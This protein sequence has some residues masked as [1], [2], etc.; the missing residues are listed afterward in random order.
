MRHT[1][2]AEQWVPYPLPMLFAFFANPGNLPRLMPDWQKAR[3]EEASIIAP[4]PRPEF[5]SGTIAAGAGTRLTLSFRPFPFSPFRVSWEAEISAFA[6]DDHFCDRQ[7]RG[8]FAYWLHCHHV[9]AAVRDGVDGTLVADRVEYEL[10]FGVLGELAERTALRRQIAA[11]FSFRQQRL[12][13][14]LAKTGPQA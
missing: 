9:T 5:K 8:P 12:S 3:I 7:L 1:F 11:T 4:P 14:L 13:E 10:P 2:H 6:W